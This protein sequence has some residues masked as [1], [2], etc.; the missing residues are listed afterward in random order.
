LP[1]AQ[2]PLAW[3]MPSFGLANGLTSGTGSSNPFILRDTTFQILDNLSV[4]RGSH[5]IRF[6]G[7]FRRDRFNELG[8]QFTF[9][10]FSFSGNATFD[11][12]SRTT[13]GHSMADLL[14]GQVGGI[15]W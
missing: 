2:T 4:V 8:T 9:S 10:S 1:P 11:P 12:A 3:G 15:Q 13:T 5:T 14:L 6:G 7:E